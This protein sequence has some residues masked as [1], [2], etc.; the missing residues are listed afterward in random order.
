M[1]L[2]PSPAATHT[3]CGPVTLRALR[4]RN[5]A[6]RR[7]APTTL[8]KGRSQG[9]NLR[10]N[11]S[12]GRKSISSTSQPR[13]RIPTTPLTLQHWLPRWMLPARQGSHRLLCQFFL[14]PLKHRCAEGPSPHGLPLNLTQ[15]PNSIVRDSLDSLLVGTGFRCTACTLRAGPK[16]CS[17]G[18]P[19]PHHTQPS[20]PPPQTNGATPSL[21]SSA[22]SVLLLPA[23]HPD[24]N[25]SSS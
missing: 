19:V 9:H 11:T 8:G 25:A 1:H 21:Y 20:P 16:Q 24:S 15:P 4:L 23:R 5:P 10:I 2:A 3:S 6:G 14:L 17:Y 7:L 13:S 22:I 18:N 12:N